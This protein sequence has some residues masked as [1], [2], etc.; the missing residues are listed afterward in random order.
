MKMRS[1]I[2]TLFAPP[3][4]RPIRKRPPRAR[5]ALEALEDRWVPSNVTIHIA[6]ANK[7][8]TLQNMTV[9]DLMDPVD[10]T[11]P[12]GTTVANPPTTDP[13]WTVNS[14]ADDGSVGTL[15]WAVGQA[16]ATGGAET[17][18]FDPKVCGIRHNLAG[19]VDVDRVMNNGHAAAAP[20]GV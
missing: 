20:A 13:T 8:L 11:I 7:P 9:A 19:V 5:L 14:T 10:P 15:R 4:T 16:N 12:N 3:A 1:W 6:S 18:N 2:R 17:I